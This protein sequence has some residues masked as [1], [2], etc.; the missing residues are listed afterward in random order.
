M[1]RAVCERVL[2]EFYFGE[3]EKEETLGNLAFLAEKK[4]EHIK[5]TELRRYIKLANNV[6]HSYQGGQLSDNELE[7]V[8][9]FLETTKELIEQAPA[10]LTERA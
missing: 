4:Y 1:C 7:I 10:K 3:D 6:M 9:Q 5:Q 8:R 2:K